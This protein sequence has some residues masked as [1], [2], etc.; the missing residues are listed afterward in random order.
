[1]VGINAIVS[2]ITMNVSGLSAPIKRH[3]QQIKK[4]CVVVYKTPTFNFKNIR[5]N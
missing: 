4:L 5:I 1:M 2:T 3:K